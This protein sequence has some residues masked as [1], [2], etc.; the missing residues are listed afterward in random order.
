MPDGSILGANGYH[1][2]ARLLVRLAP[3]LKL[4]VPDRP[5]RADV[6]AAVETLSD[7]LV[8]F[9]FAGDAYRAALLAGLLTPLAWH[10]FDGPAPLFLIDKNVRGAGA[11]LAA[12]VVGL[13]L[14]GRRFPVMS[15]TNDREELRKKI[16]TLAIESERF[17]LLDNLA[18]AVGNDVLDMALTADTWKDRVLGSNKVYDGP[19]H[20]V[21]FGTGNN[22]QLHA[23]TSRRVC[24][25]R[26]ESTE[27]RPETRSGF[28]YP[29]LRQHVRRTRDK[30]LSAALTLLR[31]WHV[32]GRPKHGLT[33]WGSFE[34]WSDVVREAVVFAGLSD[35]GETRMA[36]QTASDR[37]AAAM[38]VITAGVIEMDP[39]GRGL[40]VADIVARLKET[41]PAPEW[42]TD[43]RVAVEELCGKLDTRQ[44]GYKFRHFARRVFEGRMLDRAG[45]DRMK[46]NRWVVRMAN[47]VPR[48]R[49]G[50]SPASPVSPAVASAVA[51]DA[52]D[53]GDVPTAPPN[54][55][56]TSSPHPGRLFRGFAEQM[57]PD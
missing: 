10:L 22:V 21:W 45:E 48:R 9:P 57:L 54:D 18:G 17:V 25:V 47:E 50:T 28:K 30:L 24:H 39:G 13:T 26:M 1:P 35:P 20:V 3:D 52:G 37:D 5:T 8:D 12:D 16:T 34:G 44:L 46:G 42:M 33:P 27:E 55:P 49:L 6:A 15:Y 31:G 38:A 4:T 14:T 41:N 29:D 7:P 19:L 2:S 36:L 40:T 56:S 23:D 43:M 53:A 51:G 32:A 11:G